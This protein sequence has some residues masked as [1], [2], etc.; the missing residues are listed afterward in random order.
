LHHPSNTI[1]H[2]ILIMIKKEFF[3]EQKYREYI[4]FLEINN[5]YFKTTSKPFEKPIVV[6]HN[7]LN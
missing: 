2:L 6:T 1:H 4:R 7:S 3:K 5:I